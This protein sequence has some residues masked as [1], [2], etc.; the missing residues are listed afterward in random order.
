MCTL[1]ITY[2]AIFFESGRSEWF[3][4]VELFYVEPLGIYTDLLATVLHKLPCIISF[5]MSPD[6]ANVTVVVAYNS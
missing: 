6:A 4:P 2:I 1:F 5:H 3:L